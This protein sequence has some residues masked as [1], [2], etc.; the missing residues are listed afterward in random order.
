MRKTATITLLLLPGVGLILALIGA[1]VYV[2]FAQSLGYFNLSGA[3]GFSLDFW[4]Q[5]LTSRRFQHSLLYSTKI[6]TVSA[7]VSVAVAY[8]IAL[9]LR[10]PFKGSL[11][12]G[13]ILKTPLLV[14]GLVAAFLFVNVI[15]YHGILN[16][17]MVW[18]GIVAKPI[19]MQNDRQGF[20]VM[21]LQ[22][23]KNMPLALL[24]LSGAVQGISDDVLDAARDL[25]AN[26]WD[27]FRKVIAPL[28]IEAM[29]AA[30]VIIFIGAAGD[31]SFQVVAGP[32]NVESMAQLM[33]SHKGSGEWNQAAAVG[34]SL[35]LLALFGSLILALISRLL[36]RGGRLR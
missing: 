6:A 31:F 18:L 11:A 27:R 2:A 17:L 34:V 26:A 8:P 24:L 3:S 22:V 23:W 32:T 19:R 16:E 21:F 20:G 9:W 13:G 5:T 29:Q 28:S 36:L 4:N 30:L 14:H 15:S 33:N 7:V 35:M 25:G 12:I 1:V 10:R